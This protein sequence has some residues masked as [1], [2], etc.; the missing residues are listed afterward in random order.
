MKPN[1]LHWP[2]PQ[3]SAQKRA[4][5]YALVRL[6]S[7]ADNRQR[8]YRHRRNRNLR[9]TG[10]EEN[11]ETS[12]NTIIT[13]HY[14]VLSVARRLVLLLRCGDVSITRNKTVLFYLKWQ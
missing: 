5:P 13:L 7:A 2:T 1:R 4:W 12:Q 11:R 10:E 3:T 14:I 6:P 9:W 8:T